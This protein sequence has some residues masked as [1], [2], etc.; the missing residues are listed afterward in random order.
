METAVSS[1]HDELDSDIARQRSRNRWLSA[2]GAVFFFGGLVCL[3]FYLSCGL[4]GILRGYSVQSW[5]PLLILL[6]GVL[7]MIPAINR[8]RGL[9]VLLESSL[10]RTLGRAAPFVTSSALILMSV[11]AILQGRHYERGQALF[12]KGNYTGA[13][14]EF[15]KELDTWYLRLHYNYHEACS[16][17]R[18]A[19]AYSQLEQFEEARRTYDVMRT[20]FKGFYGGR[21]ETGRA[22]LDDGITAIERHNQRLAN[23]TDALEKVSI[24]YDLALVYRRIHCDRKAIEQYQRIADMDI[25]DILKQLALEQLDGG[26]SRVRVPAP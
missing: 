17:N 4:A 12:E 7:L 5:Y 8:P 23:E 19:Q 1:S 11:V 22:A 2:V 13:I 26:D 24:L 20:R 16:M 18:L 15:R 3:S 10:S 25:P 6:V 21:A 9:N 14:P